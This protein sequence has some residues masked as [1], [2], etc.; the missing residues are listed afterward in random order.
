M[1]GSEVS[2]EWLHQFRKLGEKEFDILNDVTFVIGNEHTGIERFD[3]IRALIALHSHAFSRMLYGGMIESNSKEIIIND[4]SPIAFEW[5]KNYCYGLNPTINQTNVV[6]LLQFSDKYCIDTMYNHCITYI[7]NSAKNNAI[8]N[9]MSII[10]D[11]LDAKLTAT[12]DFIFNIDN[13]NKCMDLV[14]DCIS[15]TGASEFVEII[16]SLVNANLMQIVDFIFINANKLCRGWTSEMIANRNNIIARDH[17]GFE[18]KFKNDSSLLPTI[19]YDRGGGGN[20]NPKLVSTF[21]LPYINRYLTP[22]NAKYFD[23][24]SLYKFNYYIPC[25]MDITNAKHVAIDRQTGNIAI[26]FTQ[27]EIGSLLVL[28]PQKSGSFKLMAN[29]NIKGEWLKINNDKDGRNGHYNCIRLR[30][31]GPDIF[32]FNGERTSQSTVSFMQYK[33]RKKANSNQAKND[34]NDSDREYVYEIAHFRNYFEDCF[35]KVFVVDIDITSPQNGTDYCLFALFDK[36]IGIYLFDPN[37]PN[38]SLRWFNV[39]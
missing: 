24:I 15:N 28:Q 20:L 39:Q 25:G 21:G 7:H 12:V 38:S 22:E 11:L 13:S 14:C 9:F 19:Y 3:C 2:K 37:N 36:W 31:V 34:D 4:V 18:F 35:K 29:H 10:H 17:G 33:L 5:Y 26:L 6:K 23:G 27:V 30:F 8:D 32:I 16:Y 1:S